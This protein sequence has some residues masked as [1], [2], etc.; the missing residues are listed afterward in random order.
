MILFFKTPSQ[1]IIATEVD[2]KLSQDETNELCWL[3]G[4]ASLVDAE[5]LDGYYV[6][7]RR[8]MITAFRSSCVS[9]C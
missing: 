4:N 3:Y 7:P 5:S 9:I 1:N 2:H 8:E 6:G